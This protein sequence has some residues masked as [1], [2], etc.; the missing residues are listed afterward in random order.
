MKKL[1]IVGF[2]LMAGCSKQYDCMH[3]H[4]QGAM[5]EV[6]SANVQCITSKDETGTTKICQYIP[7]GEKGE[8]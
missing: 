4:L 2:L 1:M 6:C 7:S 8:K 5:L 3:L